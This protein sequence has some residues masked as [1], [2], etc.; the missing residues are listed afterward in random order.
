MGMDIRDPD[1]CA[2]LAQT[3]VREFGRIDTLVPVAYLTSD[4]TRLVDAAP[5]LSNW[6]PQYE[7]NLFATLQ[8]VRAVV[9]Q[10]IQ[11]NSGRIIF[12]NTMAIRL[13]APRMASYISSKAALESVARVLALELGPHGIRVNS[14]HPGYMWG[15]RVEQILRRR[16][17]DNGTTY[18]E[19]IEKVRSGLALGYIPSTSE[20]A[21]TIVF[22]ASDLSL[23]VTGESFWVN[24]GQVRH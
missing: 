18:E 16:A 20:Y 21:G 10:M 1:Q 14:V 4:R 24:G 22:L 5:D 11:Q 8:V 7:T 19:E 2:E 15:D 3:A 23:P 17:E 12:V 13:V 6:R 9:P